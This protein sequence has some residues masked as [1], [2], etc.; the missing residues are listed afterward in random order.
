MIQEYNTTA[1]HGDILM[2]PLS[3]VEGFVTPPTAPGLGIELNEKV[4]KR[5]LAN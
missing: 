1:L 3:L 5:V 4:V 2:E